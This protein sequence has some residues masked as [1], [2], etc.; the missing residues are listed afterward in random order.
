M[1]SFASNLHVK[2]NDADRVAATLVEILA[3]S[4][5][6]PTDKPIAQDARGANRSGL[7]ALRVSTQ[8]FQLTPPACRAAYYPLCRTSSPRLSGASNR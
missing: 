8:P 6:R 3:E 2:S 7:R 5:W 4:G 1:G